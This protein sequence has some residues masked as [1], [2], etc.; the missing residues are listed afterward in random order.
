[1][2][3]SRRPARKAAKPKEPEPI[4]CCANPEDHPELQAL[5]NEPA[6]AESTEIKEIEAKFQAFL[7]ATNKPGRLDARTK[8]AMGIALSV[9]AKCEPCVKYHVVKARQEGFSTDEIEE[10]AWQGIAFGGSPIMMFYNDMKK[11]L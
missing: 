8:R 11:K 10:A 1:M 6:A 5:L 4:Q 2:P 3:E 9:L 7:A